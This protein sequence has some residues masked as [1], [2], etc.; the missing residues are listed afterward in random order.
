[1]LKGQKQKILKKLTVV[2]LKTTV[3]SQSFIIKIIKHFY[4]FVEPAAFFET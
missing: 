3:N 4:I 2:Y 1:M